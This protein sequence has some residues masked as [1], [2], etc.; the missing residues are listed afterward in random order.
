MLKKKDNNKNSSYKIIAK[1]KKANYNY[2]IIRI[3]ECGIVLLGSEVKSLR[4][5]NAN[6]SNSYGLLKADEVFLIGLHIKKYTHGTYDYESNRVRKL[7]LNRKEINI[8]YKEISRKKLTL[9]PI[10]IYFKYGKAKI[11]LAL[12]K[13]KRKIDKRDLIK[14]RET[15]RELSR[16]FKVYKYK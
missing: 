9:V 4:E 6:L 8:I 5:R 11:S 1:N 10:E 15:D 12:A 2:E 3:F 16:I 7:M 13:G 14:K